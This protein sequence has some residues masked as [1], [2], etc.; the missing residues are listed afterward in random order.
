MNKLRAITVVCWIITA[1]VLIGLVVWF[2]SGSVFGFVT[3]TMAGNRNFAFNIGRGGNLTGPYEVDGVYNVGVSNIDSI[4]INWVAGEVTVI[5]FDGSD[6]QITESS[7]RELQGNE[8][9]IY[10][11]NGSTLDIRFRE[12]SV[13]VGNM[14]PKRLEV[15]VPQVLSED[16]RV[17]SIETVS[18]G[19]TVSS[20]TAA[21]L[22]IES[23]SGSIDIT[24]TYERAAIE[25]VSGRI[26]FENHAENSSV[27][28][29][30]VSGRVDISGSFENV[31]VETVSSNVSIEST[32][33]PSSLRASSVSGNFTITVPA[34]ATIS[35][36]HSSVSGRLTNDIPVT[37]GGTDAQFR[38]S[39]VSGRTRIL[40]LND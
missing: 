19:T 13:I 31:S 1:V 36:N 22:D 37:T 8:K 25:S 10:T 40:P 30:N 38:I 4:K 6:I 5:P 29:E 39:T 24:G 3:D 14:P 32:V 2:L 18:G 11:V 27:D 15:L 7:Q 16:M 9:L 28:I 33:V 35:L 34:D 17:L 23:V 20:I 21:R 12:R 26:S